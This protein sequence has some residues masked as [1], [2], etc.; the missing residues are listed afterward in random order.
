[1][2]VDKSTEIDNPL[3]D[4]QGEPQGELSLR[5]LAMP[6]DT[7]PSG[8]IFGGWLM[9]QMDIAGGIVASMRAQGR[10]ATIAVDG[11]VFHQPVQV[12]D[13]VCCYA[14]ILKIGRTSIKLRVQA[15]V[16][17]GRQIGTRALVTEGIFTFVAIDE[18]RNKRPVPTDV[19]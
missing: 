3:S 19:N 4:S 1:M 6:S 8:D 14:K 10:V 2:P 16:L 17:R 13:V 5:T 18:K 12:G 11:F 9:G 7:N 15:W